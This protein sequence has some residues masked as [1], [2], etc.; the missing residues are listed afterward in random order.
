M[1]RTLSKASGLLNLS[2]FVFQ[3][4][5]LI[6]MNIHFL[7]TNLSKNLHVAFLLSVSICTAR[8]CAVDLIL[9]EPVNTFSV[10]SGRV[11]IG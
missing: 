3:A 6:Y 1:T 7:P 5:W 4:C 2:I 11:F 8:F 9:Y 10:T